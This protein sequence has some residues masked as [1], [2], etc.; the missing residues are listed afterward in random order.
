[1][2][3]AVAG[4]SPVYNYGS[5]GVYGSTPFDNTDSFSEDDSEKAALDGVTGKE[6]EDDADPDK[7]KK[8]GRESSPEDCET[9]KNRK[10]RDVSNES[11]VSFKNASSVSPQAAASAVRAHE[12]QHVSN[13]YKK[14]EEAGSAEVVSASVSIHTSICPE[15]GK[16]YVSGGT[17]QTAIRY[18]NESNPYE[19]S[20][21]S[22]DAIG[23]RGANANYAV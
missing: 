16:S 15:C 5:Y 10:Y 13:A 12:G 22:T 9:C 19:Q 1:M 20:R 18:K 3:G 2:V 14:A 17:T 6:S 11:N 23:F 4:I 7:T 8:A 21:K